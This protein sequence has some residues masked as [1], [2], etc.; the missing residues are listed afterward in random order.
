MSVIKHW[1]LFFSWWILPSA[2]RLKWYFLRNW[3]GLYWS[4][5][6]YGCSWRCADK[7]LQLRTRSMLQTN[8]RYYSRNLARYKISRLFS[9]GDDL[10]LNLLILCDDLWDSLDGLYNDDLNLFDFHFYSAQSYPEFS[11]TYIALQPLRSLEAAS[12]HKQKVSS[13][14]KNLCCLIS[15]KTQPS[16]HLHLI[17]VLAL[18]ASA[19]H[20]QV[21]KRF[22]NVF[23][24]ALTNF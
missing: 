12:H 21:S 2:E 14:E 15:T 6:W 10:V 3:N 16:S 1:V 13:A 9:F 24:F 23:I 17:N 7:T 11:Q 20:H 5:I 18:I 8:Y 22:S 4:C 19:F